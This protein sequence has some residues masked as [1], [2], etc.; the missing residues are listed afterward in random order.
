[1][2]RYKKL[3]NI[4]QGGMVYSFTTFAF[5]IQ[6]ANKMDENGHMVAFY[7]EHMASRSQDLEEAYHDAGQFYWGKAEAFKAEKPIFSNEATPFILPRFL[8]QDIDTPEDW[9]RAEMMYQ[10]LKQTGKL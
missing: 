7:P 10:A 5:P 1:M 6:R 8:V 2:R 4:K 3:K 9:T